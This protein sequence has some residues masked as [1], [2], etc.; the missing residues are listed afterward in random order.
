MDGWM[1]MYLILIIKELQYLKQQQYKEVY[2]LLS[3]DAQY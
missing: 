2:L 1:D 3:R